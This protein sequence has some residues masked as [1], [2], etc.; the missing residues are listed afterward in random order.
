MSLK[1]DILKKYKSFTLHMKFE[2]E[3]NTTGLLGGS[4]CGKSLTLKCIAGIETPDEGKIIHNGRLLYDSEHSV[5]LAPRERNIGFMFQNYALFPHMTVRENIEIAVRKNKM[6]RS[7][8]ESLLHR[9]H[10]MKLQHRYANQLSGGEQQRVALARMMAYEP[11]I[12]MFDEPFTALDSYLKDQLQQELGEMLTDYTGDILMV[13]HNRDELYRFCNKIAVM[14]Q[15]KVI[16]MGDK[17]DVF[18]RPL[19]ITAAKLTGLRNISR[20]RR[21]SDSE[22]LAVDWNIK[23]CVNQFVGEE[24]R[25]VGI[26][27]QHLKPAQNSYDIN[28]IKAGLTSLQEG[29]FDHKVLLHNSDSPQSE[30]VCWVLSKQDW[31]NIYQEKLPQFITLP[32]EHILL[33]KEK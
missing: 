7:V 19:D 21:L 2:T 11:E 31:R 26:R 5:N 17:E 23:L 32:K 25:Y 8:A 14:D 12:L 28:T 10:I 30:S 6:K 3:K 27:S 4:G 9:F 18:Q 24:I 13:S 22:V 16:Q 33:L 15:G 29:P 1:V 20:V